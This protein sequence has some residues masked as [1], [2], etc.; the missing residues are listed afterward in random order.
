MVSTV[1]LLIVDVDQV[2]AEV[3][4]VEVR[5]SYVVDSEAPLYAKL[6]IRARASREVEKVLMHAS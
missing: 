2:L 4:Y 1:A 3:T 6:V 5:Y